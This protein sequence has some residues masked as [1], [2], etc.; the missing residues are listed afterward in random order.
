M[1]NI[2]NEGVDPKEKQQE[3]EALKEVEDEEIRSQVVERYALDE[4]TQ[5]ETIDKLV[6]DKKEERKKLGTAIGQKIKWRDTAKAQKEQK[7]KD[8][9]SPD[10]QPKEP[11]KQPIEEDIIRKIAREEAEERDLESLDTSDEIKS[12]IK[13][14]AK[15]NKVSYRQAEKSDYISFLKQ[16]EAE[17]IKAEEASAGSKG[18]GIKAKRDFANLSNEDIKNLSDEDY[19]EYNLW[20]K[21]Q[22]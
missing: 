1:E 17:K 7:P 15:I 10:T 2:Q 12:Q 19:K 13:S 20:L 21:S 16:K 4:D 11:S 3:E 18:I 9:L 22:E 14:Y 6:E 8:E 5:S